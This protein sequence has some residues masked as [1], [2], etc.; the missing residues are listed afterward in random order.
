MASARDVPKD[1]PGGEIS[2]KDK[3]LESGAALVQNFQPVKQICAH[4]NAFHTYADEPGRYVEANHYCSHL[5][6]EIRQCILYDSPGPDAK[7]IGIEYMV[8]PSIYSTLA[9]EERKLWHSHV[10]EVKSGMLIMPD[11]SVL[12]LHQAWE[13]A[14]TEEMKEVV[15][16]YG[17]VYHLW[18]TDR[19]DALPLGEAK[20]MT[21][22][23]AEGQFDF[24]KAVG[25]RDRRFGTDWK[26][27]QE[28]R[29]GIEDAGVHEDADWAWKKRRNSM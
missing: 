14:E 19:G 21:S 26:R 28:L 20:L 2:G 15:H 7:L 9:A 29:K 16:L 10:F 11:P 17:K 6:S 1:V 24:E 4:L 23:T 18:Q 13:V 25:D 22:F 27:K 12:G 5:T 8:T 3:V